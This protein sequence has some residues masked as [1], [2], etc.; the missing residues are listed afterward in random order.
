MSARGTTAADRIAHL[1]AT[2]AHGKLP[3]SQK[4]RGTALLE[5]LMSPVRLTVM[6]L[7]GSGKSELVNLLLGRRVLP[8]GQGMP[9]CRLAWGSEWTCTATAADGSISDVPWPVPAGRDWKN[10]VFVQVSAPLDLLKSAAILKVSSDGT[11]DGLKTAVDFAVANSDMAI[12][13]TQ[14]MTAQELALWRPVPETLKDHSFMAL[15]KADELAVAGQLPQAIAA[16]SV[17]AEEEFYGLYPVAT[18]Q[19]LAAVTPD[20]PVT[21]QVRAASG[22]GPLIDAVIGD[23]RNGRQADLD[24]AE[25]FLSR[26]GID[27]VPDAT[28]PAASKTETPEPTDASKAIPAARPV[29]PPADTSPAPAAAKSEPRRVSALSSRA[30][31]RPVPRTETPAAAPASTGFGPV[32]E[33]LKVLGQELAGL[34]AANDDVRPD[35]VLTLCM[36]GFDDMVGDLPTGGGDLADEFEAASEAVILMQL[37]GGENSAAD[38]VTVVLQLIRELETAHAA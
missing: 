6:G 31:S 12:W 22:A 38:A 5:R 19:Y 13:C 14:A 11:P 16:L 25:I 32:H 27:E 35:D 28:P 33:R 29:A 7:P 18:L 24:G 15:T 8:A 17:I 1:R 26:Y 34:A 10:I 3:E 2:L 23:L 37:E 30:D 9:T 4:K 21:A 20:V 36:T